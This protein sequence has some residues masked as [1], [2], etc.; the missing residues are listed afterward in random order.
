MARPRISLFNR[1]WSVMGGGEAYALGLAASLSDFADVQILG[2]DLPEK[3]T[4]RER[5]GISLPV[6]VSGLEV[7][8]E[9]RVS[10][11]VRQADLFI[12]TS[13]NR[14]PEV[15]SPRRVQ[16]LFAPSRELTARETAKSYARSLAS[17]PLSI[18]SRSPRAQR[19]ADEW[20]P[21]AMSAEEVAASYDAC[22]AVSQYAADSLKKVLSFRRLEVLYPA[23]VPFEVSSGTRTAHIV[24]VGRMFAPQEGH[25]KRQLELVRLF[26]EI[27]RHA[28]AWGLRLIGGTGTENAYQRQ[29]RSAIA[30][31]PIEML[32]DR[33]R[34]QLEQA[35]G[36]ARIYWHAAGLDVDVDRFPDRAEHFGISVVE[37]MSA[38]VVP[39]VIGVGGP[40][41]IVEHGLSGLCTAS[42]SEMREETLRII[43]DPILEARLS[44]GAKRRAED[45]G[46]QAFRANSQRL[47]LSV[48][49]G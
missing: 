13:F 2:P 41:E 26:H 18:V 11:S 28:P 29:V 6:S 37:A 47:V 16:V 8:D 10:E 25:S 35:V 33:S 19:I 43:R 12:N 44:A 39:V 27:N 49:D 9:R 31:A 30:G 32:N 15:Q 14:F 40:R 48:L 1:Y 22:I 20:R 7:S 5:F 36:S 4:I 21:S 45:F 42:L 24:S 34:R 17:R 38:G 23:V 46:M 3:H